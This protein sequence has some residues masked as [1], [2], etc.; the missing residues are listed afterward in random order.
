MLHQIRH[1]FFLICIPCFLNAQVLNSEEKAYAEE[2]CVG[3]NSN[4]NGA[5]ISGLNLRYTYRLTPSKFRYAS[6]EMVNVKHEREEKFNTASN[7]SFIAGKVQYLFAIRP[8]YGREITLF[9]K[10]PENG[11]RLG[12]NYGGGPTIGLIKPYYIKYITGINTL[13]N[14]NI[15]ETVAYNPQIHSLLLIDSDAGT[16]YGLNTSKL[17]LGAHFRSALNFEYGPGSYSR[18]GLETGITLEAY[19]KKNIL[20]VNNEA[21]RIYS[22]FFMHFYYGVSF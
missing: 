5:L 12:F 14:S 20:L 16:L 4:T 9:N 18:I 19:T 22:A 13:N 15:T 1:V 3:F 8:S 10:Y 17:N 7:S 6:L 21:R 11:V 2:L